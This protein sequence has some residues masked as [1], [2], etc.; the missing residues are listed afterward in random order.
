MPSLAIVSPVGH[1]TISARNGLVQGIEFGADDSCPTVGTIPVTPQLE[2][3]LEAPATGDLGDLDTFAAGVINSSRELGFSAPDNKVL[4]DCA[5]QLGSYFCGVR[6]Q[7]A[8]PLAFPRANRL[9]DQVHRFLPL[10]GYGK[11]ITYGEIAAR[12]SKPKAARAV[13]TA[14]GKNQLPIVVPCHRVLPAGGSLDGNIGGY[15]GGAAGGP[16]IKRALL[17][18]EYHVERQARLAC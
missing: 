18:L 10:I 8:L 5:I 13:G 11:T 1:L 6:R 14:C 7:F 3:V 17:R 16:N 15:T 12:L 9:R 4:A 2:G